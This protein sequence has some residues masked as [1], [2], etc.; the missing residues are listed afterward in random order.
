MT[1]RH[2]TKCDGCGDWFEIPVSMEEMIRR[3]LE[4]RPDLDPTQPFF[5]HCEDCHR[6]AETPPEGVA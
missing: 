6:L 1:D 5:L 2:M 3:V 4:A